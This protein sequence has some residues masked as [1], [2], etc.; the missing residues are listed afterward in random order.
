MSHEKRA[1][2]ERPIN[3]LIARRWSPRAISGRSVERE[4]LAALF[5]AAR[6]A[7]SCFNEQPW[8]YVFA[9]RDDPQGFETLSSLLVEGNSWAKEAYVLAISVARLSF[10][11]NGRPNPHAWHDV[12]A[13]SENMFLQATELGLCM[14]EMAGFDRGRARQVLELDADHDPVAM[15]AIGYRGSPDDLPEKLRERELEPRVRLSVERFVFEGAWGVPA[16]LPKGGP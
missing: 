13:A 14:H 5:E 11:R 6:W 3:D 7:P 12:G 2:T 16:V 10:Q 15:I 9:T 4:K 1:A 8:K